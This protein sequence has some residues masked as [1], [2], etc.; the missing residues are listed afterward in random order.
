MLGE[1][2]SV[3]TSANS[4][5]T[6][7]EYAVPV[8]SS[9]Y[10]VMFRKCLLFH[11]K[12]TMSNRLS[13]CT[14]CKRGTYR[15]T[16]TYRCRRKVQIHTFYSQSL[17]SEEPTPHSAFLAVTGDNMASLPQYTVPSLENYALAKGVAVD[18]CDRSF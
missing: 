15:Y 9:C 1:W 16:Q 14:A 12:C 3:S 18:Q 2:L 5:C 8:T 6:C 7:T 11:Q 17:D 13:Y 4:T 10:H